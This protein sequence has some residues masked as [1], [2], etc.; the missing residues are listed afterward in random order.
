MDSDEPHESEQDPERSMKHDP[1]PEQ[2]DM[3]TP[4][5]IE[6]PRRLEP[7]SPDTFL[8]EGERA[9][10]P[11]GIVVPLRGRDSVPGRR[12]PHLRRGPRPTRPS[13][14]PGPGGDAA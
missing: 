5:V 3:T 10:R 14:D 13:S 8:S 2:A 11:P 4:R 12:P 1:P 6:L 9:P 7:T